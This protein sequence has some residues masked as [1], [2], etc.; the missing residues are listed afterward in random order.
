MGGVLTI[1]QV[2]THD[3]DVRDGSYVWTHLNNASKVLRF[4]FVF[5]YVDEFNDSLNAH[6]FV[7]GMRQDVHDF[8]MMSR[9]T[10]RLSASEAWVCR[11][12]H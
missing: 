3:Y 1:V 5:Q 9:G 2:R 8:Y 12:L 10:V 6:N 7:F 11:P 4:L